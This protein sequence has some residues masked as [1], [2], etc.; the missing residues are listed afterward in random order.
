MPKVKFLGLFDLGVSAVNNKAML[1]VLV[2]TDD[3]TSGYLV[4]AVTGEMGARDF[5]FEGKLKQASLMKDKV[6]DHLFHPIALIFESQKVVCV[7]DRLGFS[8]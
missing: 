6:T 2:Q 8:P 7:N 3:I 4:N 5:S 1:A